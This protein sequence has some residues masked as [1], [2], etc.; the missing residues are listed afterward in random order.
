MKILVPTDLSPLS[1]VAVLYAAKLSIELNAE[2]VLMNI[3][4]IDVL[5]RTRSE[6][7]DDPIIDTKIKEQEN[8]CRQLIHEIRQN[9]EG[10][11][12]IEFSVENGGPLEETINTFAQRHRCDLIV[13]GTKGASGLKKV[14]L[15]SNTAAVINNS[16]IPV[17]AVPEYAIFKGIDHVLYASDLQRLSEEFEMLLPHAKIFDT[18]LLVLHV[19]QEGSEPGI[20]EKSMTEKLQ[21][22]FNYSKIECHYICSQDVKSGIDQYLNGRNTDVIAMFSGKRN[23]FERIFEESSSRELIFQTTVPLLT[24]SRKVDNSQQ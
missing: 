8:K 19:Y 14:F 21:K 13:M 16:L 10:N 12:K 9:V 3:L 11:L 18:T 24:F 22:D 5:T 2:L 17:L 15:G 20:D 6:Y 23:F 4:Y 1:K 7:T